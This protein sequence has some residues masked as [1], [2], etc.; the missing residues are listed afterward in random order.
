MNNIKLSNSRIQKFNMCPKSY[1]LFYQKKIVSQFKNSSLYFGAAFDSALNHMLLNKDTPNILEE[2]I[3]LFKTH[4][5]YQKNNL[6]EE[7]EL[8]FSPFIIYSKYDYDEDLLTDNDKQILLN[9]NPD[10]FEERRK[11][12]QILTYKNFEQLN[13]EMRT[14]YNAAN[15]FCLLNKAKFMLTSYYIEL[16]PKIKQVLHLQETIQIKDEQNN[17]LAGILDLVAI[18]DTGELVLIDNKTSSIEYTQDSVK[19][20]S[21]LAL[22]LKIYNEIFPQQ[23]IEQAAFFV[24]LKKLKKTTIKTCSQ[25]GTINEGMHKTC[26]NIISNVRCNGLFNK[27]VTF[28]AKTQIVIDSI[29]DNTQEMVL[30][31][32]NQ[33]KQA[34]I[35]NTF[36]RNFNS[37]LNKYGNLCEYYNLCWHKDISNLK[38]KQTNKND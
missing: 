1:E 24:V 32:A 25:C 27:T 13:V 14:L 28:I 36:H 8:V 9:F 20:S 35:S 2:T 29:T 16:L 19:T 26:D 7:C 23:K 30:D 22:Y 38:K 5:S 12:Q 37:C 34:I 18:L 10:Y 6:D 31:N 15:W 3:D 4:W 11:I 17:I 21:Q 33:I